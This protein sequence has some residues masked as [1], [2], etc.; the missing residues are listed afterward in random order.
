MGDGAEVGDDGAP[1]SVT[2]G[3][4]ERVGR[5]G[6][7]RVGWCATTCVGLDGPPAVSS[8]VSKKLPSSIPTLIRV[9]RKPLSKCF[10]SAVG[11]SREF[12]CSRI[13]VTLPAGIRLLD[14]CTIRLL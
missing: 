12:C 13:L 1:S 11:I 7:I 4:G 6:V 2:T 14:H 9:I 3:V 8:W 5:K 10:I